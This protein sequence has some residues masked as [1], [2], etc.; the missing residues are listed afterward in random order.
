MAARNST[1]LNCG[2]RETVSEKLEPNGTRGKRARL[3]EKYIAGLFDAD[4]CIGLMERPLDRSDT[5]PALRRVY[6]YAELG[7]M[8]HEVIDMAA[9]TMGFGPSELG[10]HGE[11]SIRYFGKKAMSVLNRLK[12]YLVVKRAAVERLIDMQGETIATGDST[13]ICAEARALPSLPLPNYPSRKWMAGYLD[14]NGSFMAR[15]PQGKSSAQAMLEACDEKIDREG[16]DLMAKVFGGSIQ[17]WTTNN[18]A[19]MVKWVLSMPPSK[20]REIFAHCGRHFIVKRPQMYFLKG[21]ADT[22]NFRDGESIK[23]A[24]NDL[25]SRP[26]RLSEMDAGLV[27]DLLASVQQLPRMRQ[28][29]AA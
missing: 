29:E 27:S 4:G 14:G 18:G 28:S 17:E 6:L 15:L 26:H 21:C 12:P 5:N 24:M 2:R 1:T 25:N 19:P 3:S 10:P 13:R 9:E 22:G 23:L 8:S 16:I 20:V 11:K 7:Q